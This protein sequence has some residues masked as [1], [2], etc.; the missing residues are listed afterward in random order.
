MTVQADRPL[1]TLEIHPLAEV[2]PVLEG[3]ERAALVADIRAKGLQSPITLCDGKILDGRNRYLACIEA[4]VPIRTETYDGSDPLGFVHSANL[5]RRHLNESQRA[6]AAAKCANLQRGGYRRSNETANLRFH[7]QADVARKFNVSERNVNSAKRVQTK[8]VPSLVQA[9]ERGEVPVSL[10]AKI[11]ELPK[12]DQPNLVNADSATLRNA[13]KKP[14]RAKRE[15]NPSETIA[16]ESRG[17]G[18][19]RYGLIY[20]DLPWRSDLAGDGDGSMMTL[21]AIS[22]EA[23]AADDCVLTIWTSARMLWETLQ[24]MKGWDFAYKSHFIWLKRESSKGYCN[25]EQHELLLIGVR[26][27]VPAP[28]LGEDY[29]SLQGAE[30]ADKKW[31]KPTAFV[32]I[33]EA[34]FPNATKIGRVADGP[35]LG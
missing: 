31:A 21:D 12:T 7:S 11:A 8:G 9:V 27:N 35:R 33:I 29:L 19:K 34:M 20:V 22:R 4:D 28:A 17:L 25:R 13:F 18:Q 10:A 6:M 14:E 15:P 3:E 30:A 26:G 23:P 16:T 24:V 1:T 2:F 5:L 32:D